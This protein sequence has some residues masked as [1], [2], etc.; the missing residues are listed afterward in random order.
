MSTSATLR[1]LVSKVPEEPDRALVVRGVG[2]RYGDRWA[3]RDCT[4]ALSAGSV[5]ALVGSNGAGKTTLLSIMAGLLGPNEGELSWSRPGR[6]AFLAHDRP[7]YR[8][9]SVA[10]ML[11]L[12]RRTNRVWD[13]QRASRW[14]RRFEI[15]RDRRCG[16]LSGGQRTQ[17]ALAVA[18]GSC[19]SVLLLDEPLSNL[20]PWARREVLRQ[21][22]V[23][24]ADHGVSVVMSTHVVTELDGVADHL[25]LLRA[26]RLLMAGETDDLLAN[27]VLRT[28]P[29]A[30]RPP[31]PGEVLWARHFEQQSRF[32]M[33][34]SPMVRQVVN[35]PR[36]TSQPVTLQDL[37]LA[38]LSRQEV[39]ACSG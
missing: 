16:T 14:L 30:H 11:C 2:K 10:D 21:L 27:H 6:V 4:F 7:L 9:F 35:D 34:S 20:D 24:V 25:L 33:R 32:L 13:E 22:L 8:G 23:E 28:G 17:V 1:R 39:G 26:G 36:W 19:P 37:V 15:P 3:L 31:G 12:G 29:R 5:A 18:L 38:Y